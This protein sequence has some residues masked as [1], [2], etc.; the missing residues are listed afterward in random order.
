MNDIPRE[1]IDQFCIVYI[2]NIL[3]YFKKK[4]E[5]Y[6][7]ICKILAKLKEARLYANMEKCKMI[8][9]FW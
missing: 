8:L 2:D 4:K 1:L 7:Q 5:H 3:I 9:A 6:K